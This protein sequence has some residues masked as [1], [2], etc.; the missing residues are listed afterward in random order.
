[1][2]LG[3]LLTELETIR[4]E[5]RKQGKVFG[6][7]KV[8]M[9]SDAEGNDFHPLNFAEYDPKTNVVTLWPTDEYI[10]RYDEEA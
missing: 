6:K 2:N 4:E 8:E 7:V 9:S 1:M 10:D 3:T 5:V